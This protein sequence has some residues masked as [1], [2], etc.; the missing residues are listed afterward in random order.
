[1]EFINTILDMPVILQ[2][3]LGSFLFWIMYEATKRVI[4][5][6]SNFSSKYNKEW[7]IEHLLLEQG[8]SIQECS[9][10]EELIN[11]ARSSCLHMALNR[12]IQGI[13]YLCF[14]LLSSV[15][16]GQLSMVAYAIALIYFFRALKASHI[17]VVSSKD[18][19]WHINRIKEIKEELSKLNLV[20]PNK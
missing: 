15:Y 1:M 9:K 3:A 10:D 5:L 13:I 16:L 14:G 20:D 7:R 2:G 19:E 8:H 17:E 11:R 18:K 12:A 4:G 6:I